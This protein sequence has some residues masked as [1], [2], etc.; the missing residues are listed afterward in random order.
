MRR[1]MNRDE[2][3]VAWVMWGLYCGCVQMKK[4]GLTEDIEKYKTVNYCKEHD[5]KDD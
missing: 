3:L 1:K 2:K 4:R 5:K